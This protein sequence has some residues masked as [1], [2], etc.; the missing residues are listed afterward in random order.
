MHQKR[1]CTR[2]GIMSNLKS[3]FKVV[4]VVIFSFGKI[5]SCAEIDSGRN[6]IA[7]RYLNLLNFVSREEGKV[8]EGKL[9]REVLLSLMINYYHLRESDPELS[10]V[11]RTTVKAIGLRVKGYDFNK[12]LK[13]FFE[14]LKAAPPKDGIFIL[15][16]HGF[17]EE[18]SKTI[19]AKTTIADFE[20]FSQ[21][22][23]EE[24]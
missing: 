23:A 24:R 10:K 18:K 22:V 12:E 9:S 1:Y 19:L 17:D 4:F 14:S 5:A 11:M 7:T 21:W 16:T 15:M 6:A 2:N 13:S 8:P 20:D 3:T